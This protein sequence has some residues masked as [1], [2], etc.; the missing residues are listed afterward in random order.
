MGVLG[1]V[2]VGAGGRP[3]FKFRIP[4]PPR[5]GMTFFGAA[6][7]GLMGSVGASAA[8]SGTGV[9]SGAA[10][11]SGAGVGATGSPA[12]GATGV[13]ADSAGLAAGLGAAFGIV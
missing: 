11:G 5:V 6:G 13:G 7:V 1:R 2:P 4:P 8:I 12:K 10:T 3:A 9:G